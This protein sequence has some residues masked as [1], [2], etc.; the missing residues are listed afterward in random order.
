[1]WFLRFLH[2]RETFLYESSRWRCSNMDDLRES[3]R[4]S[5]KVSHKGLC[6]Q[7]AVKLFCIETFMAYSNTLQ[8]IDSFHT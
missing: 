1:M 4:D 5:A 2:V 8:Y 3:M 6:V 7:L